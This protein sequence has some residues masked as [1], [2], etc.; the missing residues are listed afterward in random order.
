VLANREI[1]PDAILRVVESRTGGKR[2]DNIEDFVSR[3]ELEQWQSRYKK[4]AG[5]GREDLK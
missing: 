5:F 4:V 2:F 3:Q 1:A